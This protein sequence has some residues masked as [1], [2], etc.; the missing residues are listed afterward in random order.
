MA[1]HEYTLGGMAFFSD[2]GSP[3]DQQF[4]RTFLPLNGFYTNGSLSDRTTGHRIECNLSSGGH[5]YASQDKMVELRPDGCKSNNPVKLLNSCGALYRSDDDR[6][7]RLWM[8]PQNGFTNR[9][10]QCRS[11]GG[12]VKSLGIFITDGSEFNSRFV[13]V[14]LNL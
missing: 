3:G 6:M 1:T 9:V 14:Y 5:W 8:F 4:F 12:L 2:D 10:L 11:S 7:S 13:S